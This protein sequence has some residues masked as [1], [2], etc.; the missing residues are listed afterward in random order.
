MKATLKHIEEAFKGTELA[1]QRENLAFITVPKELAVEAV[2]WLRDY[3]GYRH[4]VIVS[5]VD[6]IERGVFQLTYLLHSEEMQADIGIRVEI[7]REEAAMH[8]IHHLWAQAHVYQRELK[9]MFG[10]DF[11]GSPR[12]NEPF[13]LEGWN[14]IPPMRRDFD[15]KKYSEETYFPREGRST[16]DP[17]ERMARERYPNDE[18]IKGA[19]KRV[20][21]EGERD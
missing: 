21:R 9:E 3:A 13:I 12:V 18:K 7:D 14:E 4:L 19:I 2:T 20:V 10:I 5:A 1:F 17:S 8:S 11:P 16:V 15:T 6:W